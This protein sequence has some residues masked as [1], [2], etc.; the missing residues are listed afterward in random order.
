V[1]GLSQCLDHGADSLQANHS[2][3]LPKAADP[4]DVKIDP[5]RTDVANDDTRQDDMHEALALL[6]AGGWGVP[7]PMELLGEIDELV[8]VRVSEA[9]GKGGRRG[10]MFAPELIKVADRLLKTGF[11]VSS[12]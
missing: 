5:L 10:S 1:A 4:H 3:V 6:I 2:T 8:A 7:E 9:A 11:E 12:Y